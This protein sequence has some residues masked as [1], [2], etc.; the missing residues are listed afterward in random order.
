MIALLLYSAIVNSNNVIDITYFTSD[1]SS[2]PIQIPS[3]NSGIVTDVLN[4]LDL[5]NVNFVY[6]T[7]PFKRMIIMLEKSKTPWVTYGS[8]KW[9]DSRAKDLS[10]TP[11]MTVQHVLLTT[12]ETPYDSIADMLSKG[13]VLIRGFNYPGLMEHINQMPEKVVYV[14][15][16]QAAINMV[17]RGRVAAFVGMNLRITYHLNKLAIERKAIALHDFSD[18]IPNY[19]VNLSFSKDFPKASRSSIESQLYKL[20]QTGQLEKILQKY[21]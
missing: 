11:I 18:I 2:A 9:T 1:K 4:K 10:A 12:A 3:E 17:M 20:K 21:K 7:L 5:P 8:D 19:D 14:K 16:H 15:T 6:K 13:I